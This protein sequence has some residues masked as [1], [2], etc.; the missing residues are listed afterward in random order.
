MG[1][2][3]T[4]DISWVPV[5]YV[6]E[7]GD[8]SRVFSGQG[9]EVRTICSQVPSV[10]KIRSCDS[11]AACTLLSVWPCSVC[12]SFPFHWSGSSPRL[13]LSVT[14]SEAAHGH[15]HLH[16]AN[17]AK[18]DTWYFFLTRY[19]YTDVRPCDFPMTRRVS[20]AHVSPAGWAHSFLLV[21]SRLPVVGT[22]RSSCPVS[23]SPVGH[24]PVPSPARRPAAA[25][26]WPTHGRWVAAV[27]QTRGRA[28]RA[29]VW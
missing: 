11:L 27:P 5:L 15:K 4:N 24:R 13:A 6:P 10:G 17:I 3:G 12:L 26:R 25:A 19:D 23:V 22:C 14:V 8:F 1:L 7:L 28:Q 16:I 20:K 21:S 29:P 2:A 9:E 18:E